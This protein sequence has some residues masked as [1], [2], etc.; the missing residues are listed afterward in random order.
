MQQVFCTSCGSTVPHQTKFCI[1]CGNSLETEKS[2]QNVSN[3]EPVTF[4]PLIHT[5]P[6]TERTLISDVTSTEKLGPSLPASESVMKRYRDA[7][8]IAKLTDMAGHIFKAIGALMAILTL[9]IFG[10]ALKTDF[11]ERGYA[12]LVGLFFAGVVF[13]LFLAAGLVISAQGQNLKANLD[14]AAN[15]SPFLTSE[16]KAEVMSLYEPND[17]FY[18]FK[19]LRKALGFKDVFGG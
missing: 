3:T 1:H 6:V 10:L 2:S 15:S 17:D 11:L 5:Q 19:F 18:S 16:Q 12:A 13:L 4:K 9:I 8:H 7:Y 14:C